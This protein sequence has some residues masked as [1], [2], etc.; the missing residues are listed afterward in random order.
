MIL[1]LSQSRS[2]I[3]ALILATGCV[4]A[5]FYGLLWPSV[6]MISDRWDQN[7]ILARQLSGM[8]RLAAAT[9]QIDADVRRMR[10]SAERDALVMNAVS[11]QDAVSKVEAVLRAHVAAAG[12]TFVSAT[13]IET[14]LE[15]NV[16]RIQ[17]GVQAGGAIDSIATLLERIETSRP[18]LYVERVIVRDPTPGVADARNIV[19]MEL[20][21]S[22]FAVVK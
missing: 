1:K 2:R 4:I 20:N 7:G 12:A 21:V 5:A 15:V 8:D 14:A 3:L 9:P 22:A 19:S 11:Q 17:M 16:V 13:P 6:R 10:D 18:R